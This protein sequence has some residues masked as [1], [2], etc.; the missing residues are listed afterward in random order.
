M[1]KIKIKIG[2]EC[3]KDEIGNWRYIDNLCILIGLGNS[4]KLIRS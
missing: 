3:W 2:M 1:N 4:E